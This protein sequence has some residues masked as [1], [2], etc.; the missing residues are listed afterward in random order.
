MVLNFRSLIV[1][2]HYLLHSLD[3]IL[4][5]DYGLITVL[6]R[7]DDSAIVTQVIGDGENFCL[8]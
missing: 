6:F 7:S 1:L 8:D 5:S 4:E 2:C 3:E